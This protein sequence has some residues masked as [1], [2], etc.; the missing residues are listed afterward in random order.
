MGVSVFQN[1]FDMLVQKASYPASAGDYV[2]EDGLIHCGICGKKKQ[3]RVEIVLQGKKVIRTPPVPCDCRQKVIDEAVKREESIER[4]E[5]LKLLRSMSLMD[6]KFENL[7]FSSLQQTKFNERPLKIA[8]RYVERFD[9]MYQKCQ[10]MLFYG[11]PGTGKSYLAAA[12]ANELMEMQ[13]SIIMTSFVK[14]L[15]KTAESE[16]LVDSLNQ[17][18]LLIIDDLGAERETSY[19]LERVYNVIDSRYRANKPMLLT[20]NLGVDELKNSDN[21]QYRRVYDRI[22]EICYPVEFTG[23]SWRRK[24]AGTRYNEMLKLLEED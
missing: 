16:S 18:D 20:T 17:A 10:G 15:D 12:I 21:I 6:K 19:A 4:A 5:K 7:H 23:P 24:E 14:I 3:C 22:L 8:H 9:L 13:K 11:P 2:G 1:V